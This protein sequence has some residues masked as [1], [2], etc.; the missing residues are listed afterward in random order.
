MKLST[1]FLTLLAA[2]ATVSAQAAEDAGL[3]FIRSRGYV[4]CGTDLSSKTLA[5]KDEDGIWAGIDADICRNFAAAVLGNDEAFRLKDVSADQAAQALNSN[6][7]DI[8]LGNSTLS[9]RQ[10]ASSPAAAMDVLYYDK[11]VFAA[12]ND[13]NAS[14]MEAFK[15]AKVCVQDKSVDLASLNEYNHKYAMEFN[16]LTFPN[17]N[18]AKQAFYLNRCPLIAGSEIYLKGLSRNLVLKNNTITVLPEIIAYRPIYAYSAKSNPSLRI[19]GKWILN[20]PKLAEQ[21]GITSKNSE[22]FIGVRDSSLQNLLG[23]DAGLWQ[24]FGLKPDWAGKALKLRGN[25]GEMFERN[26]GK[27][28]PLQI[29]RDKNYLIEKGGL[30]NA[31]PFI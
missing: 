25:F 3:R 18:A 17:M 19:I 15:G 29:E 28:S 5:Y 26:L 10:E 21:Q 23:L 13:S 9:A 27:D 14:S 16:I 30:I 22:A 11:Q 12:R 2:L 7:I 1:I 31:L 24:A 20:A 8:M 6:Q 4:I